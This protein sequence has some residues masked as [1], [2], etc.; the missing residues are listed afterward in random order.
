MLDKREKL[1]NTTKE[2]EDAITNFIREK[3]EHKFPHKYER[4]FFNFTD[5]G[6]EML[7]R[8]KDWQFEYFGNGDLR[9]CK[10]NVYDTYDLEKFKKMSNLVECIIFDIERGEVV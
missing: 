8:F 1:A 7:I 5:Y 4:Y 3:L 10:R 2:F 6:C 9:F